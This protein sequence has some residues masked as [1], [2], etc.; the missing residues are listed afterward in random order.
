LCI[1]L[2][3]KKLSLY[4]DARSTKRTKLLQFSVC[5]R[6][7]VRVCVA[8]VIQDTRR[9]RHIILLSVGCLAPPYFSTVSYRRHDFWRKG[10]SHEM[11]VLNTSK[12]FVCNISRSKKNSVRYYY[13]CRQAFMY[14]TRHFCEIFIELD[15]SQQIF[16]GGEDHQA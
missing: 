1:K 6:A 9:M 14:S 5:V 10:I 7:R 16:G 4:W 11:C 13:K 2:V 15:V 12:T 3:K 8:L